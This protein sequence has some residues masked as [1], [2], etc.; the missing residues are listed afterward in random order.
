MNPTQISLVRASFA[1][2]GTDGETVASVFYARLFDIDPSTKP[3]FPADLKG[4]RVKLMS[5]LKMVVASL[6]RLGPLIP[7]IEGL[8]RRHVEYGVS[9]RQY[10]SVGSALI[11]TLDQVLGNEFTPATRAAWVEAYGILST[12]M[13]A[14]A[15]EPLAHCTDAAA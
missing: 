11:W 12:T 15:R 8:A 2:I 6:D 7:V 9:E 1:R 14:A 4:Q 13:I 10:P 3:L 5:V